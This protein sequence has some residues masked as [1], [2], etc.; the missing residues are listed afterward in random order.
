[1]E[2]RKGK[3]FD[4]LVGQGEDALHRLVDLPGGQR[5]LR[6]FN[7]LKLRVDDLGKRVRGVDELEARV[8]KLER[9]VATL[10]RAQKPAGKAPTRKAAAP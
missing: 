8:A 6:V 4:E 3:S 5:A 1:V 9:E 2:K 7:D 10:K